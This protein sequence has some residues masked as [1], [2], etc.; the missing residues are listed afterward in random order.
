MPKRSNSEKNVKQFVPL[1][2]LCVLYTIYIYIYIIQMPVTHFLY[3]SRPA[4]AGKTRHHLTIIWFDVT[5]CKYFPRYWP[6]AHRST[7]NS[8]HKGQ[9]S[10]ALMFCLICA[11][12]NGW[13][14][15]G[16]A[17][18]LRCHRTHYDVTVMQQDNSMAH[19]DTDYNSSSYLFYINSHIY[20]LCLVYIYE[21]KHWAI[22]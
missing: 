17:G 8:P 1:Q 13:V 2:H 10:G 4:A 14:N 9:W 20:V 21:N 11:W 5:K 3:V 19:R 7:V 22:L 15:N 18:D 6:F 12:I 16:G